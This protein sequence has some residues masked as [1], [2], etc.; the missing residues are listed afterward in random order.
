MAKLLDGYYKATNSF[1]FYLEVKDGKTI[2]VDNVGNRITM[3]IEY[4][5]LGPADALIKEQTGKDEYNITLQMVYTPELPEGWKDLAEKFKDS[6]V[7]SEDGKRCVLKNAFGVCE[8]IKIT[9]EEWKAMED[10]FDDIEAPPGPYKLQPENQGKLIWFS[11]APGMGKST[12]A[13]ILARENGYVYYEADCFGML[14]NP[15]IPLD[16]E[17]PSMYQ[18]KMKSLKGPGADERRALSKLM[19]ELLG[20]IMQGKEFDNGK[21][22]QIYKAMSEDIRKEKERIG[23]DWAVAHVVLKRESRDL[24]R[25]ILGPQLIFV[26][27]SMPKEDRQKR[28]KGRHFG[29][30]NAS[31]MMDVFEKQCEPGQEGEPNTIN[32]SVTGDMTREQVVEEVQRQLKAMEANQIRLQDGFYKVN[33]SFAQSWKIEGDGEKISIKDPFDAF[34]MKPTLKYGDFGAVSEKMETL[35]GKA[36][37]NMK[38]SSTWG[39]EEMDENGEMK[40]V[41]FHDYGV[42]TDEGT[43]CTLKSISN[44][45]VEKITEKQLM[46]IEND[47]DPIEAPPGPYKLQPGKKGKLLWFSGAPGMGKSTSAQLLARDNGYVYYEADAFNMMHNPFNSLD[48]ENPSMD[49]VKQK[50]LKGP[51]AAERSELVQKA[52]SLWG[53][54]MSGQEY[55]KE[56]FKNYYKEMC[57]DIT[58]QKERIGGDWAIAHVVFSREIRDMMRE[59]FGPDLIFIVLTMSKEEKKKRLMNRHDG[60]LQFVELMESFEKIM[61]DN[62]DKSVPEPNT[63]TVTVTGEMTRKQVVEEVQKQIE[64]MED[65]QIKL[66]DGFYKVKDNF[67]Q[68]WKVDG[69]SF[70][71]KDPFEAMDFK[72]SLEYGDFGAVSPKLEAQIGKARYNMKITYTWGMGQKDENGELKMVPLYDYGVIKEGGKKVYMK[73]MV[74]YEVEKITEEQLIELQND[75]DPIEAPPGPYKVQPEKKGKLLWFSGA[76]G[77]GKSTSAQILA[78]DHGYVYYEADAF[79][80]MLNPFNP[81]D[82]DNPSMSTA[83]QKTLKGPGAKERAELVRKVQDVWGPLMAGLEYDKELLLEYYVALCEDINKQKERIGGDWA[84]AHVVLSKEVRDTLRR[85]LGPD[86]VIIILTMSKEAKN[87][88]L[89][90][91]H[92]G[93]LQFVEMMEVFENLMDAPDQMCDEP[94]CITI[95][96]EADETREDVVEKIRKVVSKL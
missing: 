70:D 20:P 22:I 41:Y 60:D 56:L 7:L 90:H 4:G 52:Q 33:D 89:K 64:E 67:I 31:H 37:Y 5:N 63:I 79:G 85:I 13:Q 62:D 66:L 34:D 40:P 29:D 36:R 53:K 88:R 51:G 81:L 3:N 2:A 77:M 11:G 93:N 1:F 27:L 76:P 94:F 16:V 43:R 12:T 15:Y 91:R 55:D 44:Y 38:L 28:I 65:N 32:V 72:P 50:I 30:E 96:V 68:W 39:M 75:Y 19:H 23:G 69:D 24:I 48:S 78:R 47:F 25:E 18:L 8:Y 95:E 14:K 58:K 74:E 17:N 73:G 21:F 83:K 6:G 26:I 71:M 84:V 9:D 49:T 35:V 10:N 82:S 54:L 59:I 46:E 45:S 57:K 42:I 87:A 80:G 61:E 86:L 92:D